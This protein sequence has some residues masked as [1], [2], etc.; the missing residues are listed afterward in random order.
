MLWH[1]EQVYE[2]KIARLSVMRAAWMHG[3][4]MPAD[5]GGGTTL[6][7]CIHH[8]ETST[9]RRV[10]SLQPGRHY[11]FTVAGVNSKG[12]GEFSLHSQVRRRPW[13]TPPH[14]CSHPYSTRHN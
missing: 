10:R 6:H 1:A 12:E 11:T 3:G 14:A 9:E 5:E 2:H 8:N 4:Q 13:V 7:E